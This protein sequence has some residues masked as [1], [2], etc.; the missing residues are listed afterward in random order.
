MVHSDDFVSTGTGAS[1]KWLESVLTKEFKIKTSIIGPDD[2]DEKE[3]KILNR[4]IRYTKSGIELEA[5]LR[6][7]ELIVSQLG[8]TESKELTCPAAEEVKRDDDEEPL[9]AEYTTQYKSIG[10]R[11]NYLSM[12][13]PDNKYE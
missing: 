8:L 5:D 10:A 13:R 6:H 3:I 9:N 4:I 1:L 2:K 12:D 11:A 7:A